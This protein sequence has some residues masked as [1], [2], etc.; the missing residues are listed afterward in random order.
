MTITNN[1]DPDNKVNLCVPCYN[2]FSIEELLE[3]NMAK[4]K[5]RQ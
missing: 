3:E 5:A 4:N 1:D 2:E